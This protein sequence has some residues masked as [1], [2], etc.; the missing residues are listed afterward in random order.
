MAKAARSVPAQPV[1]RAAQS[2][3]PTSARSSPS[4]GAA[5]AGRRFAALG[6]FGRRSVTQAPSLAFFREAF[7][8]LKKVR[9]PSRDETMRLTVAVIVISVVTAF[10]LGGLDIIFAHV[11]ALIVGAR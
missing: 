11:V 2:R 7:A 9:W 8:E 3:S 5:P 4:S 10:V 1:R 6:A